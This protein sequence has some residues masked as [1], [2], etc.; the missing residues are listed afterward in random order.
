[1]DLAQICAFTTEMQKTC[2][3]RQREPSL[4]SI[5]IMLFER[6]KKFSPTLNS[7]VSRPGPL[8]KRATAGVEAVFVLQC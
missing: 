6:K 1:M 2:P 3:E 8:I 4:C 7:R 5:V